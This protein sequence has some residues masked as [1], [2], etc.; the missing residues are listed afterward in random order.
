MET[1]KM[2]G[3]HIIPIT[4]PQGQR[5]YYDYMNYWRSCVQNQNLRHSPTRENAHEFLRLIEDKHPTLNIRDIIRR[6]RE[7]ILNVYENRYD[8]RPKKYEENNLIGLISPTGE[9]LLPNMFEDVF[10]QFDA[11][12]NKPNFIPVSNGDAWALIS[13]TTAPVLV[14]EFRYNAIIPERWE[15]RIF[16][17]QDKET[18]KWGALRTIWQSTNTKP[19]DNH[20][21]VTIE[22]LMPCIADDIYEDQLITDDAPTLFF[23]TRLGDKIGIMTDHGY[24]RISYD[25][26]ETD[27]T[28]CSFRL[29]RNDKKRTRRTNWWHPDGKR[30]I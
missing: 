3:R 7:R 12:K 5:E 8:W 29:I 11:I 26:Y 9:Q 21:L 14:T 17:V 20:T 19:R 24:S 13:L 28:D 23:M 2:F 6:K 10:T 25:R 30:F 1:V 4:T 16:F 15:R 22:S 18:M 27:D